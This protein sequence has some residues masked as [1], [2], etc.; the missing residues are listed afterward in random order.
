MICS[1][2]QKRRVSSGRWPRIHHFGVHAR[3]HAGVYGWVGSGLV[4]DPREMRYPHTFP[5]SP[6]SHPSRGPGQCCAMGT[7]GKAG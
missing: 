1:N 2:L 3:T 7:E 6:S 4:K 5:G